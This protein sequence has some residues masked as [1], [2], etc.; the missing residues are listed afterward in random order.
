MAMNATIVWEVRSSA[1]G[2]AAANGGGG[3][4]KP[5]ASGTDW[6]QQNDAQYHLTGVT[7][8]GATAIL[9][10]ASASA[11]MVGNVAHIISGTNFTVGWYEILSVSAGVSITLDQACATGVGATGVVNIGG[12]I[13]LNSATAGQTDTNWAAALIAGQTVWVNG[14]PTV[15]ATLTFTAGA[16]GTPIVVNGYN[17][18]RGDKPTGSSRP[19]INCAT[20][21]LSTGTFNQF[22]NLIITGTAANMVTNSTAAVL[23]NCKLVNT[24]TTAS[25]NAVNV[26]TANG[27]LQNCEIISYR[28]NGV[29]TTSTI[30]IL[31]CYIHDSDTGVAL[32]VAGTCLIQDTIIESCVTQA[33]TTLNSTGSVYLVKNCT[34]Y[35]SEAKTGTGLVINSGLTNFRIMNCIFYGFATAIND[36]NAT[37]VNVEDYNCFFNNTTA[38]T[39]IAVGTHSVTTTPAFTSVAQITG[40]AGTVASS[41]MTVSSTTGIVANQDFCYIVSGTGATAGQYLITA[42][43]NSTVITLNSAPGGSGTNIVYQITTGRNFAVGANMRQV[44]FPGAFPVGLTTNYV[45]IGAAQRDYNVE[46]PTIAQVQ[47]GVSFASGSLTGTLVGGGVKHL[48]PGHMG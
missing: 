33:I 14:T 47:S 8:S 23:Q 34:F 22:N 48:G 25:R 20:F 4:F 44:G 43:V 24:S 45:D 46:L 12:C 17:S 5:G 2:N 10:T 27:I 11:D 26:A 30:N 16:S 18:A 15:A 37:G 1:T 28:G 13:S 19:T 32:N 41:N 3:G 38:R 7:T 29:N 6:S 39:N 42:V 40:T 36:G 35:G 21:T 31:G 9:L